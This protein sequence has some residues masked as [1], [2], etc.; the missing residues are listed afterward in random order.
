[1]FTSDAA[2]SKAEYIKTLHKEIKERIENKNR[3]LVSRKNQGRKKVIFNPG[4]WVWVHLRKEQFLD[5]RKSKLQPRGDSHFQVLERINDNAYKLDLRGNEDLDLGTNP[6]KERGDDANP[7]TDPMNVPEGPIT[8][9]KAKKI[10]EHD[11]CEIKEHFVDEYLLAISEVPWYA[12]YANYLKEI[13]E[14]CHK[15]PYGGHFAGRKTAA[16]VLQ[17]R[18]FW[19]S[20]FRDAHIFNQ[21]CDRYQRSGN[22]TRKH[23]MPLNPILEV[24]LFDVW[25]IN[26]M[27]PFPPSFS[28]NYIL[29]VVDYISKWVEALATPT[30]DAKVVSL[31]LQKLIFIR[32]GTSRCL[33]S[34]E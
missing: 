32:Y 22:L 27:G 26:F 2:L 18:F 4:D 16:K 11:S 13:L 14:A 23:E 28:K 7:T 17:S 33:I 9:S 30:N 10:Q 34:D 1:M 29:L 12:D 24:E 6:F 19:P 5:Q 8:R 25:G 31:I 15:S 3:K 20:L 21:G